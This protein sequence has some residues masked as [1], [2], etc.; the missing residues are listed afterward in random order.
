MQ[1][2]THAKSDDNNARWTEIKYTA[3]EFD[4]LIVVV[5]SKELLKEIYRVPRDVV[6]N[7][8]G[9]KQRVIKWD[10]LSDYRLDIHALPKQGLVA[11]FV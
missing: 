5:L 11:L 1:V 8:A 3:D 7:R 4:E 2:K 10:N 9:G 6:L